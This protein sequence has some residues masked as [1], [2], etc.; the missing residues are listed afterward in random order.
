MS[1]LFDGDFTVIHRVRQAELPPTDL[2]EGSSSAAA[3]SSNLLWLKWASAA[4]W[5]TTHARNAA[6]L[7][8]RPV[9]SITSG[10]KDPESETA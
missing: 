4:A 6:A 2:E 7:H 8:L 10:P 5:S 9:P 3:A 1:R